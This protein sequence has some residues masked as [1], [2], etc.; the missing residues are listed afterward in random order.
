MP[1]I[2]KEE[3]SFTL[4]CLREGSRVCS[5]RIPRVNSGDTSC[6]IYV[7]AHRL[8]F[9]MSSSPVLSCWLF[10]HLLAQ[11]LAHT[12]GQCLPKCGGNSSSTSITFSRHAQAFK[13]IESRYGKLD[14][15][16]VSK[17]ILSQDPLNTWRRKS[18][19]RV[20]L[21]HLLHTWWW[22]V[23]LSGLVF[24]KLCY[25]TPI[26]IYLYGCLRLMTWEIDFVLVVLK[27]SF[28]KKIVLLK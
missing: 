5:V 26:F 18:Q 25:P 22:M 10:C 15:F 16:S 4:N 28:F 19:L 20:G 17:W 21:Q 14:C 3:D 9:V 7:S 8:L 27:L 13:K 2:R 1:V 6:L 24:C 12:F 23:P 11:H